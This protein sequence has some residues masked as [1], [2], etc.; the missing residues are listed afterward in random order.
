MVNLLDLPDEVLQRICFYIAKTED[1]L[2]TGSAGSILDEIRST[3]S[4]LQNK[5]LSHFYLQERCRRFAFYLPLDTPNDLRLQRWYSRSFWQPSG[6]G[7][8]ARVTITDFSDFHSQILAPLLFLKPLFPKA[9]AVDLEV[10]DVVFQGSEFEQILDA[11]PRDVTVDEVSWY[12]DEYQG[13]DDIT[14]H[15]LQQ[16]VEPFTHLAIL[17]L[18]TM[19]FGLDRLDNVLLSVD[20]LE[21]TDCKTTDSE[22]PRFFGSILVKRTLGLKGNCAKAFLLHAPRTLKCLYV[23]IPPQD[24]DQVAALQSLSAFGELEF[25]EIIAAGKSSITTAQWVAIFKSLSPSL[26]VL[27]LDLNY[28]EEILYPSILEALSDPATL[29]TLSTL[30]L[31]QE[32][33]TSSLPGLSRILADICERRGIELMQG[34]LQRDSPEE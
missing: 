31:Y 19:P 30:R 5:R 11:L 22:A 10:C 16:L 7:K 27:R 8:M 12:L 6:Y 13:Q 28:D 23:D 25:L 17:T 21:L 1:A 15:D 4:R 29:A 9:E 24:Q 20:Q 14:I 26:Q 34:E 33:A 3:L 18:H 2:P 32:Q